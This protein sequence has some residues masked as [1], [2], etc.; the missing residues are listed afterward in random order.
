MYLLDLIEL[1]EGSWEGTEKYPE[2]PYIHNDFKQNY[3]D[4]NP[5]LVIINNN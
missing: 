4:H 3:S 2:E 1:M 5:I